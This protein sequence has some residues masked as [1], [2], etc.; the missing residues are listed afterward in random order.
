MDDFLSP[1]ETSSYLNSL[2]A[3]QEFPLTFATFMGDNK[4][5]MFLFDMVFVHVFRCLIFKVQPLSQGLSQGA[6]ADSFDIIA[7][8]SQ[9]VKNF[10]AFFSNYFLGSTSCILGF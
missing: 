6:L 10:F 8:K 2:S 4:S 3:T 5:S 1:M 7:R 9:N